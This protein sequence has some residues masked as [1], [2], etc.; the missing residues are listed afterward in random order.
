[1]TITEFF[2]AQLPREFAISRRI[3][4]RVPAGRSDWKPHEKSM[5]FGYLATLVATMPTWIAMAVDRDELDVRPQEGQG[6]QP[7]AWTTNAD[8]LKQFEASVVQAEKAVAS[9]HDGFLATPWKLLAGGKVV[10]ERPRHE[11]IADTLCHAS[12]HRGQLSV[13]LRLLDVAIPSIYGP[14]ADEKVF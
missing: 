11:V 9:T 13:Y 4:E 8:L 7:E 12:H 1:M 5:P 10:D 6:I 3:L 2:R 14:S